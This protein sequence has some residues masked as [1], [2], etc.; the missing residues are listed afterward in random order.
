MHFPRAQPALFLPVGFVAV[1]CSLSDPGVLTAAGGEIVHLVPGEQRQSGRWGQQLWLLWLVPSPVCS[2]S[3]IPS[4]ATWTC[5]P[6]ACGTVKDTAGCDSA[7][8][9]SSVGCDCAL[10]L[11]VHESDPAWKTYISFHM[12]QS[13]CGH[14]ICYGRMHH[15]GQSPVLS[16]HAQCITATHRAEATSC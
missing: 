4:C 8:T 7:Y 11:H 3:P 14:A 6:A 1:C 16:G 12:V 13:A 2:L 15:A 9:L 5:L 10:C